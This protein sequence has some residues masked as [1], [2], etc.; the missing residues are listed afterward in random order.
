VHGR[1]GSLDPE[2]PGTI[3]FRIDLQPTCFVADAEGNAG[4]VSDQRTRQELVCL[5]AQLQ[6]DRLLDALAPNWRSTGSGAALRRGERGPVVRLC[7]ARVPALSA[8][9]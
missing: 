8:R 6:R 1:L 7:A 3:R 4:R 9:E 2:A 5:A